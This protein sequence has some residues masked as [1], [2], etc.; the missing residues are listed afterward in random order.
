MKSLLFSASAFCVLLMVGSG[1]IA[2]G[3]EY[4]SVQSSVSVDDVAVMH[5]SV[6]VQENHPARVEV[7]EKDGRAYRV[8]FNVI[9]GDGKHADDQAVVHVSFFDRVMGNWT[10]RGQPSMVVWVGQEGSV[11]SPYQE[12]TASPRH[13][14]VAMTVNK[15]TQSQMLTMF[16]GKIPAIAACPEETTGVTT[17]A[18]SDLLAG[19]SPALKPACCSSGCAD[20]SGQTMTCCGA[21]SCSARGTSCS[22]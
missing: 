16:R 5:P 18:R 21:V 9:R 15:K 3:S 22:P 10:L 20:G 14:K 13:V 8:E 19:V 2:A 4:Y 11:V 17:T 6:I 1:A 7:V 12:G